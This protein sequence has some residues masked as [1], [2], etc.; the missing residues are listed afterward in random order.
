MK[1]IKLGR[2]AAIACAIALF[3]LPCAAPMFCKDWGDAGSMII[4][5]C[6][7]GTGGLLMLFAFNPGRE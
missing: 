6:F 3:V 1:V 7:A 4:T 2:C 5:I